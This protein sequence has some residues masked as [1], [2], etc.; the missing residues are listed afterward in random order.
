MFAKKD[1]KVQLQ[2]VNGKLEF[3]QNKY[4]NSLYNDL[5][6]KLIPIRREFPRSKETETRKEMA[7]EE[8]DAWYNYL[9]Q[10]KNELP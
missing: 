9:E 1:I 10:R 3:D 5:M 6:K 4:H 8:F 2:E 7:K